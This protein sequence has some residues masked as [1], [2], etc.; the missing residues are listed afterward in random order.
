MTSAT[1]VVSIVSVTMTVL[2]EGCK[3]SVCELPVESELE[4]AVGAPDERVLEEVI[5]DEITSDKVVDDVVT[6][7]GKAGDA[8]C[9]APEL[10]HA[11]Q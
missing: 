3:S 4:I 2:V 8:V 7:E 11:V 5:G 10:G 6:L 9:E 1:S